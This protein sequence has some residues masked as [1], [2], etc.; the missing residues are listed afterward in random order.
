MTAKNV[1]IGQSS[2]MAKGRDAQAR[3]ARNKERVAA[4]NEQRAAADSRGLRITLA[5]RERKALKA[6]ETSPVTTRGPR[7]VTPNHDAVTAAF[8]AK[9]RGEMPK[10]TK[11]ERATRK[12]EGAALDKAKK[13]YDLRVHKKQS[14][15]DI[16]AALGYP[17]ASGARRAVVTYSR[18]NGLP[19]PVARR[20]A[21]AAERFVTAAGGKF[22]AKKFTPVKAERVASTTA[23]KQ[24]AKARGTVKKQTPGQKARAATSKPGAGASVAS[25][26]AAMKKQATPIPKKQPVKRAAPKKAMARQSA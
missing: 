9:E 24:P 22:D 11:T 5:T 1:P 17:K 13:A 8:E 2:R 21:A 18:Q 19:D 3:A 26:A 15:T 7:P 14:F 10:D 12:L 16:A 25:V 4:I 23:K 6:W 20:S